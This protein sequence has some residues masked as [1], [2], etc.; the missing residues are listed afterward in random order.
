MIT[1]SI[2]TLNEDKIKS[3]LSH[4]KSESL[5]VLE[6]QIKADFGG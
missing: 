4:L 3:W 6:S 1:K 5:F 2:F